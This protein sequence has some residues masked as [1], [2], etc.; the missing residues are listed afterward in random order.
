MKA[1]YDVRVLVAYHRPASLIKSD[2]FIPVHVGRALIT[3]ENE[4]SYNNRWLKANM[5]GDNTGDNISKLN[6]CYAELTAVYWAW[7][8]YVRLGN[9]KYIGL[10]HYRRLMLFKDSSSIEE[11]LETSN[12]LEAIRGTDV[13]LLEKIGAY[14]KKSGKYMRDTASQY[15]EVHQEKDL[16][17]LKRIVQED[18]PDMVSAL[19]AI[20]ASAEIS[21]KNIFVMKRELFMEYCSFCFGIMGRVE[22]LCN[23]RSNKKEEQRVCGFLAEILLN[24]WLRHQ[25][26][27]G[28]GL[29]IKYFKQ[30]VYKKEL[31][32]N[33]LSSFKEKKGIFTVEHSHAERAVRLWRF[34]IWKTRI[35][36][37]YMIHTFLGVLRVRKDIPQRPMSIAPIVRNILLSFNNTY[38][39]HGYVLLN[40]LFRDD[41]SSRFCIHILY[42]KLKDEYISD[43]S[44]WVSKRGHEIRF[45]HLRRRDFSFCSIKMGDKVVVESYYRLFAANILPSEI[46]TILY[47]DTDTYQG[48][49]ISKC[50]VDMIRKVIMLFKFR[51]KLRR[52]CPKIVFS[53]GA[54]KQR[55]ILR[56]WELKQKIKEIKKLIQDG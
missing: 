15:A 4:F 13:C 45:Y 50:Q 37:H 40:S 56:K 17:L 16:N 32:G 30:A 11:S 22:R 42:S 23:W 54:R 5:I 46:D 47:L 35:T 51:R 14:S 20:F 31:T 25:E 19:C 34:P 2:V 55:Y 29:K 36:A 33:V 39:W 52:I 12:V 10:M 41:Q 6:M 27:K 3:G 38:Y 53:W 26:D 18:Y 49:V 24:I 9:P 21:W 43:L 48:T 1:K 28:R 44:E 7:K 8:N